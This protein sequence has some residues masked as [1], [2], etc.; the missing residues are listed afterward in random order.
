MTASP[1]AHE[2]GNDDKA[3]MRSNIALT[4]SGTAIAVKARMMS[5]DFIAKCFLPL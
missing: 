5:R 2:V 4:A 3:A 1:L